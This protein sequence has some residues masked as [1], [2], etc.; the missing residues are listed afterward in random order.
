MR[1]RLIGLSI[2]TAAVWASTAHAYN[3]REHERLPDQ[4]LQIANILRRGQNLQRKVSDMTGSSV[5]PLDI[6]PASVPASE[7]LKWAAFIDEMKATP[8]RI[9]QLRTGLS[10]P[11]VASSHCGNRYP[12]LAAGQH[13]AQCKAG[14]IPFAVKRYWGSNTSDC[15]IRGNY[16]AGDPDKAE[17][18]NAIPSNFAG[19]LL[20]YYAQSV[21]DEVNDSIWWFSITNQSFLSTVKAVTDDASDFTFAVILAPFACLWSLFSGDNCFDK[22][23]DWG[24]Q[25]NPVTRADALEKDFEKMLSPGRLDGDDYFSTTGVWHFINVED[26]ENGDFNRIA[27]MHYTQG[28]WQHGVDVLGVGRID[29]L[30][31]GVIVGGDYLGLTLDPDEATG[32]S[33]YQQSPDG[34]ISRRKDDWYDGI[35]HTEFE[36]L[37]NLALYGWRRFQ[38]DHD[39]SG[40]GWVFHAI[41]DAVAPHHGIAATGWGHRPFEDFVGFA[42]KEM[43]R[44]GDP[45]HYLLMTDIITR[46]YKWWS[47]IDAAQRSGNPSDIPIR[48]LITA[49]AQETRS[50]SDYAIKTSISVD[51]GDSSN[52]PKARFF[53]GD[54][55]DQTRSLLENGTGAT[56]AFLVK[57]SQLIAVD[58]STSPCACPGGQGRIAGT[59]QPCS[60]IGMVEVNGI[61]SAACPADLPFRDPVGHCTLSCPQQNCAGT[62]CATDEFIDGTTCVAKCSAPHPFVVDRECRSSCPADTVV[63]SHDPVQGPFYCQK[64]FCTTTLASN[65]SQQICCPSTKRFVDNDTCV[66]SCPSNDPFFVDDQDSLP[67]DV[68][69]RPVVCRP[70]CL[71]TGH[72][73]FVPNASGAPIKCLTTCPS[74]EPFAVPSIGGRICMSSC[75]AN[76]PFHNPVINGATVDCLAS[77]PFLHDSAHQCLGACPPATPF[78]GSDGLCIA[79]CP[80]TEPLHAV[81]GTC[82]SVCPAATPFHELNGACVAQCAFG[83]SAD[84]QTCNSEIR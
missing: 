47:F 77:C 56:L 5:P 46:A 79:F 25:A 1:R 52:E 35:A 75:P 41:G 30:D 40:L 67:F 4:A 69:R 24:H 51:Y 21:D 81:D 82:V 72:E 17:F 12:L 11:K 64:S 8:D 7:A 32:V 58:T 22:A 44:E 43:F 55:A 71:G 29:A 63:I 9:A 61:C 13:L 59:C 65:D 74:T 53:Y 26:G 84:G 50:V 3:N 80:A 39:A 15:F 78:H 62:S 37:D 70:D 73:F 34:P 31:W 48:D 66:A 49:L 38:S 83:V 27:G 45:E 19:A 28:G 6:R 20:G 14:D 42:W 68:P 18:F 33:R 10:D 60:T 76:T 23:R 36:P 2:A 54:T 16:F 57:A